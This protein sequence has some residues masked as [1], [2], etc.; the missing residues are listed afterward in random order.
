MGL[1][2]LYRTNKDFKEYVD[3]YMT[4][5]NKTLADALTD[6]IVREYAEWMLSK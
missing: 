4:K 5:H 1:P 6:I 2:E 3:K